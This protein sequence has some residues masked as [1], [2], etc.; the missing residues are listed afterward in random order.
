MYLHDYNSCTAS[1]NIP[2]NRPIGTPE[3]FSTD[4]AHTLEKLFSLA[5]L[6][7]SG[8]PGHEESRRKINSALQMILAREMKELPFSSDSLVK[9]AQEINGFNPPRLYERI[10][11]REAEFLIPG[12]RDGIS[13][14]EIFYRKVMVQLIKNSNELNCKLLGAALMLL[15]I[16]RY[17]VEKL[18]KNPEYYFWES[19]IPEIHGDLYLF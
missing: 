19:L 3:I 16:H 1:A 5:A 7:Y 9:L 17:I 2:A 18:V 13:E 8:I 11:K 12:S 6:N 10:L 4:L 15:I 14:G